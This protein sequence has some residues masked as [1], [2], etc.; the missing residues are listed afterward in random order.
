MPATLP[1]PKMPKQPAKNACSAPSRS[2]YWFFRKAMTACATVRR[3]VGSFICTT[4]LGVDWSKTT[5]LLDEGHHLV[6][7]GHE[8]R[9]AVFGDDDRSAGVAQ[10]R[11][12]VPVPAAQVSEQKP[13]GE[14]VARAKNVGYLDRETRHVQRRRRLG[15]AAQVHARAVR[16]ALF[17]QHARPEREQA[18]DR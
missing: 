17:H 6:V 16:A 15:R 10:S 2:T 11:G 14:G 9:A 7:G 4:S 5:P 13:G 8:V 1:C 12:L 3:L 18:L